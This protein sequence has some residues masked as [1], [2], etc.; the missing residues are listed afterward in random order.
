MWETS[1]DLM[2]VIDF[3]GIFRRVNPAWKTI[4]GYDEGEL[5]GHHVNDFV[6]AADHVETVIAYEESAEGGKPHIENRYRH[7]DATMRWISWVAAP[8]GELTY[9]TGRD[10]TAER[11][12]ARQLL[13][14]HDIVQSNPQPILA[15]DHELIPSP[16]EPDSGSGVPKS[17]MI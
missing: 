4:L 10:I 7:K 11:E 5:L 8:A 16:S 13:L 15:F 3:E 1:P 6:F 14:H 17:V 12:A 9:A 2:L